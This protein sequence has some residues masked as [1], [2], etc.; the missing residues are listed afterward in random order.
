M[1]GEGRGDLHELGLTW[2]WRGGGIYMSLVPKY[3]HTQVGGGG[4]GGGGIYTEL[5]PQV[6]THTGLGRGDLH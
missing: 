4:G 2:G 3:G 6:W 1:R 5:S